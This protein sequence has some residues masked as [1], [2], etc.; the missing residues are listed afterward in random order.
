MKNIYLL[1]TTGSIGLQTIEIILKY[2]QKFNVVGLSFGATK[3]EIHEELINKLDPEVI[4]FREANNFQE[5]YPHKTIYYG[6]EGL[7]QFVSYPKEGLVVNALSGSAGLRPTIKAIE[8]KKDIALANKETLVMA[9]EIIKRLLKKHQ[10]KLFPIDSEHNAILSCLRGEE[11]RD[12]KT[13][14]LTASGGP[15]KDLAKEELEN[16]TVR[17]ALNHPNWQM[18]EKISI[19]SATMANKALEII[20]AHYLFDLD[21]KNIKAV[22]HPESIVHGMVS[23][24]DGSTKALL[25]SP[26]MKMPILYALSYPKRYPTGIKELNFDNLALNFVKIDEKRFPLIKLAY[27]VGEKKGLYPAVFNAANEAAVKLFL[28]EKIKFL[29]I[30]EIVIKM[31][32]DFKD[33]IIKPTI[34]DII[35]ISKEV[36]RKVLS[37]Y[38]FYY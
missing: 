7:L 36:E 38:G 8:S 23:F 1:G 14:T 35:E 5:K 28:K 34:T 11:K 24:S 25:S 10:V 15:F 26:D 6:E 16:V 13:I 30:E 19:D 4:H 22:I 31:V 37:K 17:E 2:P 29:E 18:G 9:G 32:Q 12:I 21:Y 33:N 27:Y 20:E 3:K